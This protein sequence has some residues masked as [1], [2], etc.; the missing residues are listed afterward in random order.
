MSFAFAGIR[1][2]PGTALQGRAIAE[3]IIAADDP[4]IEPTFYFSPALSQQKIDHTLR[5]TFANR[6]NRVYP[7]AEAE[8][9][10]GMLHRLGHVGPLWD[11]LI[12]R[13]RG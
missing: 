10:I 9:R 5:A 3:E 6:L 1:I 12:P 7:C 4:L 2:L 8:G 11:L 13:Q